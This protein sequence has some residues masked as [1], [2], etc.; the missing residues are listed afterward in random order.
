MASKGSLVGT[1]GLNIVLFVFYIAFYVVAFVLWK[2]NC[3]F[4]WAV[5]SMNLIFVS[6]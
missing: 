4:S 6:H 1:S 2:V 3:A 5:A